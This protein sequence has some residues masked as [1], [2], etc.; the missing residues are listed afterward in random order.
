MTLIFW[1]EICI[2]E[3]GQWLWLSWKSGRFRHQRSGVRIHSGEFFYISHLFIVSCGFE[4]TK[5]TE[6]RPGMSHYITIWEFTNVTRKKLP[7]VY[8]SCPKMISLEKWLIL[9]P[10]QKLPK[11][12]EYLGNLIAAKGFKKLSKF[13]KIAQSGHTG[14][15]PI[16]PPLFDLYS[17]TLLKW[18]V[19]GGRQSS[20]V[21]SVPTILQ[22][23]V[24]IPSTSSKLFSIC[25]NEIV[26]RKGR[27][28]KSDASNMNESMPS[29]RLQRLMIQ[30]WLIHNF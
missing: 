18:C 6:K 17:T 25:I 14:I 7:N 13:Q 27:N 11:N 26:M 29:S 2:W 20:V 19:L 16:P 9:T 12:G 1:L 21:L 3:F 28:E 8:K 5:I 4:K 15:Y 24:W 30:V 22:L 23:W 10:L